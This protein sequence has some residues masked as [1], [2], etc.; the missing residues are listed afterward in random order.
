MKIRSLLLLTLTI[1]AFLY[2]PGCAN[3]ATDAVFRYDIPYPVTSLDPQFA[4]DTSSRMLIDNLFEGLLVQNPQGD[5]LPGV[6]TGYTVSQDTCSYTFQLRQDAMWDTGKPVTADDFVFAFQRMFNPQA[7]SPYATDFFNLKNA[8]QV[9]SGNMSVAHL[10]VAAVDAHTL[11]FQLEQPDPFFLELVASSAAMPCNRGFFTESRGR[12]GLEKKFLAGNGPFSLSSWDNSRSIVLQSSESYISDTPTLASGVVVYIGRENT[13]QLFRDKK[14]DL[15]IAPYSQL[16]SLQSRTQQIQAYDKTTWC[17]VFNQ[18]DSVFGNAL[19]RQ[20][21][22]HTFDR[23]LFSDQL[24][25]NL[26]TTSVFVPPAMRVLEKSYRHLADGVSPIA[27]NPQRGAYLYGLGLESSELDSL[28]PVTFYL[29]D[30]DSHATYMGIAQQSWQKHLGA[31][32]NLQPITPQEIEQKLHSGDYQML[33]MPFSP[34][35]PSISTLLGVFTS[36]SRQNYFGYYN[37]LYDDLL[38]EIHS[39]EDLS[40][41]VKKYVQAENLLLSD[42]VIL[43]VYNETTYYAIASGVTGIEISPFAGKIYFKYAQKTQ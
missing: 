30:T 3:K 11:V 28:P 8:Q 16:E 23:S 42:S 17:I 7:P 21:L 15:V 27:L 13:T 12:Y 19:V 2:L 10:G 33:L 22:A 1:A 38:R 35:S 40:G 4:T 43:P 6:A 39:Q 5:L 18:S 41:M 20:G 14:S 34:A 24:T 26:Q 32:I 25:D 36:E 31:Y 37:L 29:P 9:L